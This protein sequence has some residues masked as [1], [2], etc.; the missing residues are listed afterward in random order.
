MEA[1]SKYI[2]KKTRCVLLPALLMLEHLDS[3]GSFIAVLCNAEVKQPWE[4]DVSGH[5]TGTS[6]CIYTAGSSSSSLICVTGM[7]ISNLSR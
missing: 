5:C 7:D 1:N 4:A 2:T 3:V 6:T